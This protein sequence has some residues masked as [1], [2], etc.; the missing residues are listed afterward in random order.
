MTIVWR[1]IGIIVPIT[2]VVSAWLTGYWYEDESIRNTSFMSWMLLWSG[3]FVT[4]VGLAVFPFYKD[5]ETQQWKYIGNHDLFWIPTIVW[6]LGF[7][8]YSIYLFNKPV[9]DTSQYDSELVEQE[10]PREPTPAEMDAAQNEMDEIKAVSGLTY[11]KN[12]KGIVAGERVVKFYNPS[13]DT[14]RLTFEQVDDETN[15]ITGDIPP[16][17]STFLVSKAATYNLSFADV[18][19]TVDVS[20]SQTFESYDDDVLYLMLGENTDFLLVDVTETCYETQTVEQLRD[21]TWEDKIINRFNGKEPID[22]YYKKPLGKLVHIREPHYVPPMQHAGIEQIMA[23][24]PI[25]SDQEA[26]EEF[27]DDYLENLCYK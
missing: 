4:L 10:A 15:T 7:L 20:A 17:S 18:T 23:L 6:G 25:A 14:L 19:R 1:G 2:L 22:L 13:E 21:K 24:I 8:F 5:E 3:I 12:P 26:T 9:E 11:K 27:L 16:M